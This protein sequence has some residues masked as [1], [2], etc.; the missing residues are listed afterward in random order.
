MAA[1]PK[2]IARLSKFLSYILGRRPDEFGLVPDP[3]GYVRIKEL[4]KALHEEEG[5]RH[6]RMGHFNEVAISMVPPPIEIEEDRIRASDR[7][8]LPIM[9]QAEQMP[10]LLYF[11]VR[12]RAYPA[13]SEKGTTAGSRP[14]LVLSSDITM[15]QRLGRRIDNQPV[16]LTVQVQR[17]IERGAQFQRYGESLYLADRIDVGTFTGPALPKE[18]PE[19]AKPQKAPEPVQPKTPGSYFPDLTQPAGTQRKRRKEIDW[20]KDR[21]RARRH[22]LRHQ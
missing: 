14:H 13:V 21:R 11:T 22:K 12:Q 2:H 18:K 3:Q 5:W 9:T 1:T 7:S 20:K 10:K 6:L 15:A 8:Q 17:A 16:M 4:L 19:K